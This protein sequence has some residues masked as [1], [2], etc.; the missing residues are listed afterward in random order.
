[1][2]RISRYWLPSDHQVLAEFILGVC[3]TNVDSRGLRHEP[4]TRESLRSVSIPKE[5]TVE[6]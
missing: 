3:T 6:G 5:P 1:V 2:K 4:D